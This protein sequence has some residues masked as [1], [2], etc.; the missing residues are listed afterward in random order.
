MIAVLLLLIVGLIWVGVWLAYIWYLVAACE[1]FVGV[2][3]SE[4]CVCWYLFC[5][6]VGRTAVFLSVLCFASVVFA[7]V[8]CACFEGLLFCLFVWRLC[9][10]WLVVL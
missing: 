6:S 8:L 10:N 7:A 3:V 4:V 1:L 5:I 9:G 2:F